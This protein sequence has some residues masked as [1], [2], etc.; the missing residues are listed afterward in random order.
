MENI[1]NLTFMVIAMIIIFLTTIKYYN[2][3]KKLDTFVFF[4]I[5]YL[6]YYFVIPMLIIFLI[7]N[8]VDPHNRFSYRIVNS[9]P[10]QHS[11]AILTSLISYMFFMVFFII[12]SKIKINMRKINSKDSRLNYNQSKF[13]KKTNVI[14][15][16]AWLL[17]IVSFFA[18]IYIIIKLGGVS[19]ALT[20]IEP[21]R[22]GSIEKTTYLRTNLLFLFTIYPW[23]HGATFLFFLIYRIKRNKL[24]LVMFIISISGS[25]YALLLSGGR[26]QI[27]LFVLC[28]FYDYVRKKYKHHILMMILISIIILVFLS[29]IDDLFFYLT[30]GYRPTWSSNNLGS[31][32]EEFAFPYA[33]ILSVKEMNEIYGLRYGIDFI[34]WITYLV[35]S[36]VLSLLNIKRV[37]HGYDLITLFH[38]GPN[39]HRGGVPTDLFTLGYRQF[40]MLGIFFT[41]LFYSIICVV[42][43]R[44][45][46]KIT[47][48]KYTFIYIRI[49]MLLFIMIPYADLENFIRSHFSTIILA[50]A[51]S[52]IFPSTSKVTVKEEKQ[53]V[54]LYEE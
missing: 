2:K 15:I 26:L 1:L 36:K 25:I 10:E 3:T 18:E 12:N 4:S 24:N 37:D 39:S 13:I 33:N 35:P 48:N 52:Y 7:G 22:S 53:E 47:D 31:V 38:N 28:F 30:H 46:N 40:G 20:Q 16:F 6:L 42:I 45:T 5:G 9:Y 50:F 51:V 41:M 49:S 44:I 23:I 11:F 17:F 32:F 27:I 21:L 29:G 8:N 34:G 19:N 43:N 14:E 54:I